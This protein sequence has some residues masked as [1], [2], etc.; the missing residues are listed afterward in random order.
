M[1]HLKLGERHGIWILQLIKLKFDGLLEELRN[2]KL[3]VT[4]YPKDKD[5]DKDKLSEYSKS[6][7]MGSDNFYIEKPVEKNI[8]VGSSKIII[9]RLNTKISEKDIFKLKVYFYN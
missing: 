2:H 7:G 8:D 9:Q 5:K 4:L 6:T 1:I 3:V